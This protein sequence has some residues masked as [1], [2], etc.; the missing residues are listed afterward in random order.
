[1]GLFQIVSVSSAVEVFTKEALVAL[2]KDSRERNTKRGITGVLLYKD[3]NFLHAI[4]GEQAEV[5]ALSAKI[6][7]DPRH[8]GVIVLLRGPIAERQFQDYSMA[9]YDLNTPE[10]HALPGYNDFLNTPLTGKE[11]LGNPTRMQKLLLV[12]KKT[13][14]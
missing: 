8:T 14:R 13:M 12:F 7:T 3:G 5:E 1:M 9:F 6:R 10:V 2:L 11:F 4:E